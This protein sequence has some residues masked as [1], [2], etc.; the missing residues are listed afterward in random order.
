MT[1]KLDQTVRALAWFTIVY[2]IVEGLIAIYFGVSDS[3][4]A[5]AGFGGDSLLEFTTGII[6]LWCFSSKSLEIKHEDFIKEKIASRLIG[7]IFIVLSILILFSSIFALINLEHPK[8][9]LPGVVISIISIIVMAFLY[10]AK[11]N[12]GIEVKSLTVLKDACCTLTCIKLSVILL[13][14][15]LFYFIFPQLWWIDS[16]SSCILAFFIYKE[17]LHTIDEANELR[18]SCSDKDKH[19]N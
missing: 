7:F 2:N 17:G 14:G 5:L 3:S 19:Q 13:L 1:K 9:T 12:I 10:F 6:V 8:T 15:S 18:C 16:L 11:R 4:I